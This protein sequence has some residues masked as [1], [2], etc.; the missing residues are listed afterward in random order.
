M[1]PIVLAEHF[2]THPC[3]SFGFQVLKYA[4]GMGVAHLTHH[5]STYYKLILSEHLYNYRT[6]CSN[7]VVFLLVSFG[8]TYCKPLVALMLIS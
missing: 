1:V 8:S 7:L 5:L 4:W 2:Y 6:S 3:V